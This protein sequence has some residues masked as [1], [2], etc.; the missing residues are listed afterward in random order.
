MI[1][2]SPRARLGAL[3]LGALAACSQTPSVRST[4]GP[5]GAGDLASTELGS[6]R[7]GPVAGSDGAGGDGPRSDGPR[8]DSATKDGAGPRD[9]SAGSSSAAALAKKLG[10][11]ARFLVGMGNDL[12]ADHNK[13]GAYTLGVTLDLHYCY[14]T[15]L[16]GQGG[17]PD[18]NANGGFVDLMAS[19]A[20]AHGVVPMFSLYGMAAAGEGN[21]SSLANDGYMKAYWESARL[22]FQRLGAFGQ[23]AVVHFE[24]DFWGFA[25]Q[26]APGGDPTKVAAKVGAFASECSA[27]PA[28]LVGVGRCLV[29]LARTYAPKTVVG[30]HASRWA[31]TATAIATFLT[32]VGAGE[33]D[34][35][36]IET[37][38]R[39]A[40]CFEAHVDPN[41]QRNDGPWYWDATNKTSP[42]FAE[43]L[44]WA[45][46]ISQ[47]VGKPLLWWQMPFGVPSATPGGSAGRYR[48]NRVK[49]LFDHVPEFVAAGGVGATFGVGAGNQTYITTDGG[50]FKAAVT[51]YFAAPTPL[52]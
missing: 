31:G 20:R 11:P 7:D 6:R 23:P 40:G 22:L 36:V 15:G 47:G 9:G 25:Q 1:G 3:L 26:K 32:Q 19:T 18:W 50:Q 5:A 12:D 44:A 2:A 42:N 49:Y 38:D 46:S 33:A 35:V 37:L 24:A 52:P 28:T 4:D 17:W 39:D 10:R 34:L 14:L 41:C 48:D 16:K 29:K 13:D 51:K 21:L 30:F 43:H 8:G 45:K 27:L